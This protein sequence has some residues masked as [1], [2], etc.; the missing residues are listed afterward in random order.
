MVRETVATQVQG[1]VFSS[2]RVQALAGL[3]VA[4]LL[5]AAIRYG[6]F[7]FSDI[8]GLD[9]SMIAAAA[10]YLVGLFLMRR[11]LMFP[12]TR[13]FELILPSFSTSF[14]IALATLF[15]LRLEYQR[16]YFTS[17]FLLA[18][19]ITFLISFYV[20]RRTTRRFYTIPNTDVGELRQVPGIEWCTLSDPNLPANR[21]AQ[22]VAD[23]HY[24]H[25]PE[26]ERLLAEAAVAGHPVY[27]IKQLT[28]SL[29]GCVSME[30]LSENSFGSLMPN[31][32]YRKV[33]RL[34]DIVGCILLT[35]ILIGPMLLIALAIRL[36]SKGSVIFR[37][38]R[39]G[40]RGHPFM[41]YK[42]RTMRP[43]P[44]FECE[45]ASRQDAMTQAD[46]ARITRIG[47]F[48]RRTR[49]DEL[50]QFVNVLRGEMSWIGPRPEAVPLSRW[51]EAE[52]PFYFY[53]HIVRPGISGW[54][55]VNQGH[56]ADLEA[57]NL[58]LNYDF[59]Y[60][61]NFSASLDILIVL[62]TLRTVLTGFGSK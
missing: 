42:F 26:W 17:T 7:Q 45:E 4:V 58:K 25:P 12:G 57:V 55:Q 39:M 40:F 33:K 59:Y 3:V 14:A 1:T 11:V 27:H 44:A 54:A 34:A 35:P 23:L 61:K 41:M 28:E 48:L 37:Q 30:H 24:D 29:T 47:R 18:V 13:S 20:E 6:T 56:V 2:F 9:T 22:I 46:D 10:A 36:D 43:R 19:G 49:L 15:A 50:P 62:R 16:I 52:I 38:E 60:I 21:N 8:T 53:R 31:L 51:Y 5:P 32:A